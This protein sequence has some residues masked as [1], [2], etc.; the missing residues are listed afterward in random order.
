MLIVKN[1]D[2]FAAVIE[3]MG[4]QAAAFFGFVAVRQ[5]PGHPGQPGRLAIGSDE[6]DAEE[7]EGALGTRHAEP[8]L[9]AYRLLAPVSRQLAFAQVAGFFFGEQFEY[10][11]AQYVDHVVAH[12]A[13]EGLV[14]G[15]EMP[16]VVEQPGR[17]GD[18]IEQGT[19]LA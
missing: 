18:R 11:L 19:R 7:F 10:G 14:D 5:I 15:P 17:E 16:V 2:R 3:N 6:R 1:D 4:N 9:L 12:I 8:D 13:A